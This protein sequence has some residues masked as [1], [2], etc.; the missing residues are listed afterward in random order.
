MSPLEFKR[1]LGRIGGTVVASNSALGIY[2]IRLPDDSN[3][4]S[5]IDQIKNHPKVANAEPNYAYPVFKPNRNPGPIIFTPSLSHISAPEVSVPVAILDTGLDPTLGLEDSVLASLDA[6]NPDEPISDSLGHGTQMALIAAGVVKPYGVEEDPKT[7]S[8]IIPIRA[9][10]EN[11]F[12]SNFHLMGSIDF[13][14]QN[15]ARV[16]SLSWGSETRSDFLEDLFGY[17]SSKGLIIVAS[18]GNEPTGNPVYP[19]AYNSVIGVGALGPDGKSWGK[20]NYGDFVMLY[21]PGFAILPVGYKGDPGAYAGTSI[22]TAFVSNII[23]NYL[24]RNPG[25]TIEEIFNSLKGH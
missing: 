14:I 17:A 6:L 3:V 16:V 21:A 1:L 20:S 10:D 11:G 19:A 4:P 23:A 25:A 5:F 13:A 15:G 8:P 18:A 12:T 24:S 9:F 7:Y 22:S 2:R